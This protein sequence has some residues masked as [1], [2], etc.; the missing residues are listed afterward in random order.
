M[1]ASEGQAPDAAG[2]TDSVV[3]TEWRDTGYGWG[4]VDNAR[5]TIVRRFMVAIGPG[6]TTLRADVKRCAVGGFT[7]D[8]REVRGRCETLDEIPEKFQQEV[9]SLG[10]KVQQAYAK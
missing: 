4:Q 8:G 9:D 2:S 1:L 6:D 3:V 5:A 10:A 7:I